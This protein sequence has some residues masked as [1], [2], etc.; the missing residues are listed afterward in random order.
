MTNKNNNAI[1]L[2]L[3]LQTLSQYSFFAIFSSVFTSHQLQKLLFANT[4]AIFFFC[5]FLKRFYKPPISK[6]STSVKNAT[7]KDGKILQFTFLFSKSYLRLN[8]SIKVQTL[9]KFVTFSDL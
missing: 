6:N 8:V 2:L 5:Y 7:V 1:K 4:F 3:F 9:K